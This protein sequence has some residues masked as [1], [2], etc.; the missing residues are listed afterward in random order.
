MP[1]SIRIL[2]TPIFRDTVLTSSNVKEDYLPHFSFS[3]VTSKSA[4]NNHG[5]GVY[6][7]NKNDVLVEGIMK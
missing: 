4:I 2:Y 5:S 3:L 6:Q 7:V 1:L